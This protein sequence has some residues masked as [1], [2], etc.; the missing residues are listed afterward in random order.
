MIKMKKPKQRN[1]LVFD[2]NT[3]M[4]LGQAMNMA[5]I[6]LSN[7]QYIDGGHIDFKFED[8]KKE[9]IKYMDWIERM[10]DHVESELKKK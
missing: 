7:K 4:T 1:K 5:N 2:R 8:F 6:R 9:T 3:S 10:R